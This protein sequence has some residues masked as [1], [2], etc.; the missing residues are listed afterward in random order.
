MFQTIGVAI[1]RAFESKIQIIPFEVEGVF[2]PASGGRARAGVWS[3]AAVRLVRL[4]KLGRRSWGG[5]QSVVRQ[6]DIKTKAK[7]DGRRPIES[8]KVRE[9]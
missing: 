9:S 2:S 5:Q 4:G 8:R 3:G 6:A 1:I 7:T